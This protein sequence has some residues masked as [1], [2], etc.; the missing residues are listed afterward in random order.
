ML[1]QHTMASYIPPYILRRFIRFAIQRLD[2]LDGEVPDL[3]IVDI[4]GGKRRS[5]ELKDL[6]LRIKV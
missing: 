4:D 5:V 2:I 6:R 3:D 1:L